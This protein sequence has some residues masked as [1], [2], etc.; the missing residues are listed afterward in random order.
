M[1]IKISKKL[2]L[3]II[4]PNSKFKDYRGI[5]LETFNLK[6]FQDYHHCRSEKQKWV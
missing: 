3:K 5:Y 4:K 1:R 2:K 6:K